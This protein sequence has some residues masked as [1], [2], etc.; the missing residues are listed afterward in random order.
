MTELVFWVYKGVKILCF[1][2]NQLVLLATSVISIHFIFKLGYFRKNYVSILP[3]HGYFIGKQISHQAELEIVSSFS[4]TVVVS[5]DSC[6]GFIGSLPVGSK[7]L[8]HAT[9]VEWEASLCTVP[10]LLCLCCWKSSLFLLL[11]FSPY[12]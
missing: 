11:M 3:F 7:I 4:C 2:C 12:S 10:V 5:A 9:K 1:P 6:F 8:H